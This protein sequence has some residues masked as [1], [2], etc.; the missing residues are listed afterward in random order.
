MVIPYTDKHTS[1]NATNFSTFTLIFFTRHSH[2][3]VPRST[4]GGT[5]SFAFWLVHFFL[6]FR[7]LLLS[8]RTHFCLCLQLFLLN[9]MRTYTG[10][11][12][13]LKLM[14]EAFH[15]CARWK[16]YISLF[17][18]RTAAVLLCSPF[19]PWLSRLTILCRCFIVLGYFFSFFCTVQ[20]CGTL[21]CAHHSPSGPHPRSLESSF[22]AI[23]I[24]GPWLL[25]GKSQCRTN[26]VEVG[27][28]SLRLLNALVTGSCCGSFPLPP[29]STPKSDRTAEF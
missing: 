28:H 1:L 16:I 24:F 25:S 10:T 6:G 13:Y 23:W 8:F 5:P 29:F 26:N 11:N 14:P 20:M 7:A 2:I 27:S 18:A 17:C 12:I 4:F 21:L 15:Y 22:T 9:Y 3:A 19:R